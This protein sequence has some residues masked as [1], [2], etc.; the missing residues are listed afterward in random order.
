M[1]PSFE[2]NPLIQEHEI[3]SRQTRVVGVANSENLVILACTVL[4]QYSSVMDRQTNRQ[5]PRPWIRRAS[6]HRLN[7]S[8]SPVLT[9]TFLFYGIAKNSTP[10]RIKTPDLIEI[11]FGTVDYVG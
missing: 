2:G 7:G 4:I 10:H 8:L 11:K 3:S 5:T 1:T 6:Y 9:T